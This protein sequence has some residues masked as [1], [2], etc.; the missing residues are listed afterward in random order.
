MLP[1]S[2]LVPI[3]VL[4]LLVVI[5]SCVY[6]D[7]KTLRDRG[8]PVVLTTNFLVID[9]PEMWA[10]LCLVAVYLVL[11]VYLAIRRGLQ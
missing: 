11:P 4:A 8:T 1:I 5:A 9:T 2:A 10:A 3:L 7:A 6:A